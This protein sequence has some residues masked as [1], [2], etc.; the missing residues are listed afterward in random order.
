MLTET[1]YELW[2]IDNAVQLNAKNMINEIRSS[3][4]SRLVR[5]SIKNVSG[6]YP[7]IKM[8]F[9]VQYESHTLELPYI[10]TLEHSNSVLEFYDQPNSIK[11]DYMSTVNEKHKRK[12]FYYTPDFFVIEEHGAKWVECKSDEDLQKLSEKDPSRY[13]L[14]SNGNW[15]CP[16]GESYAQ[17]FNL[18][19]EV[20]NSNKLHWVYQ[21]NLVFLS[22]YLKK[23]VNSDAEMSEKLLLHL[24]RQPGQSLNDLLDVADNL[25]IPSDLIYSLIATEKIYVDLYSHVLAEPLYTPVFTSKEKAMAYIHIKNTAVDLSMLES[26]VIDIEVGSSLLWDE[27]VWDILNKGQNYLTIRNKQSIVDLTH[28]E[29]IKFS[30]LGKIKHSK[31]NIIMKTAHDSKTHERL[32]SASIEDCRIANERMELILPYLKEGSKVDTSLTS[33]T[34]RNYVF[35]YKKNEQIYGNGYIGLLPLHQQKGNHTSRLSENT[36]NLI[37]ECI[38]DKYETFKQPK[39]LE[40]YGA[41]LVACKEKGVE[42]CSYKTFVKKINS[43]PTHHQVK[44]RKGEKAAYRFE[45]FY[46]EYSQTNIRHGDRPFEIAHLDHTELDIELI[47]PL[48]KKNLGRPWVTFLTDAFTRK[49]LALYLTFDPPSYRSAMMIFRECVRRY[50]RLPETIVVDGGKE[51]SSVYFETTLA[52][53]R[54][55]KK[56]RPAGKPRY[57]SVIERLFGTTNTRFIYN[58]L[59]NTQST[60]D[61][62]TLTPKNNPKKLA[63]WTLSKFSEKLEEFSY[64]IYDHIGHPALGGQSPSDAFALGLKNSGQRNSSIIP[65]DETFHILTMPSTSKGTAKVHPGRGFKNNYLHYW[66]ESFRNPEVEGK[67]IPV[68]YD[69]YNIGVAYAYVGKRWVMCMSDYYSVFNGKTEKQIKIASKELLQKNRNHSRRFQLEA[70]KIAEFLIDCDSDELL[71]QQM[72]DDQTLVQ[73]EDS[74]NTKSSIESFPDKVEKST[75]QEINKVIIETI[76]EERYG[77]F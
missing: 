20:F 4:P 69:P 7:S 19:F 14:D 37:E 59:G 12:S 25:D 68:R 6:R 1:Q 60:K 26:T 23:N 16:P 28:A 70:K 67:Q 43:R 3:Q 57:G 56:Q 36:T 58:L 63:V 39:K 45:S 74:P 62:R 31:S 34:I 24:D 73:K 46:L 53:F 41:F 29:I 17:Q 75:T 8:N 49:I 65:F 61:V 77:E 72:K 44:K 9:T 11:L 2:L 10:H 15:R 40:V 38:R 13:C 5:S 55:G 32:I 52:M 51:F 47:D 50:S 33:R 42:P 76:L 21:R 35:I 66:S 64:D 54:S 22:T 27:Q 18:G 48:T 30:K 71:L